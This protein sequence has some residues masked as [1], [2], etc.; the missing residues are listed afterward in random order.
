MNNHQ[1]FFAIVIHK[2]ISYIQLKI[3][4]VLD[5][6][7]KNFKSRMILALK[8]PQPTENYEKNK[9]KNLKFICLYSDATTKN[10]VKRCTD[11]YTTSSRS[12]SKQFGQ[13]IDIGF[14]S[15]TKHYAL[16]QLCH[17]ST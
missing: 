9:D 6:K 16:S 8:N 11:D 3:E 1:K 10:L 15:Q 5:K 12:L 13:E 17:L 2:K 4:Q 7:T 14:Y